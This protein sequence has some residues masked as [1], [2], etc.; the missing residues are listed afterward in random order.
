MNRVKRDC[1]RCINNSLKGC[2]ADE[3]KQQNRLQ[4]AESIKR[5]TLNRVRSVA[6]LGKISCDCKDESL[7]YYLETYVKEQCLRYIELVV[8]QV[9]EEM[10][11]E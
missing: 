6:R 10:L 11:R 9:E 4:F 8:E 3:C 5:A 2:T 1:D 7:K